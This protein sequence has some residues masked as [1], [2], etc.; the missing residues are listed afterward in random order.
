MIFELLANLLLGILSL[1][2][3]LLPVIDFVLPTGFVEGAN[4]LFQYLGYFLPM[5]SLA[6]LLT[7]KIVVDNFQLVASVF[8]WIVSWLPF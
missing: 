3:D 8:G 1:I 4:A 6:M 7:L 5:G 2:L